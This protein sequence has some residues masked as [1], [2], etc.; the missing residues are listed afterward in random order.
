LKDRISGDF[1][2]ALSDDYFRRFFHSTTFFRVTR[3]KEYISTNFV[4]LFVA[5]YQSHN[6]F[7]CFFCTARKS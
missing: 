5:T 6:C 2:M 1:G 4:V 3:C 7:R